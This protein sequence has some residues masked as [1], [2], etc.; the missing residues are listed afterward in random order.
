M[1]KFLMVLIVLFGFIGVVAGAVNVVGPEL[2]S[3]GYRYVIGG[4]VNSFIV[5]TNQQVKSVKEKT[6]GIIKGVCHMKGWENDPNNAG[7]YIINATTTTLAKECGLGWVRFDLSD[8][9][10]DKNGNETTG[11]KNFKEQARAYHK[12]GFKVMVVTPYP[13]EYA[14]WDI[15]NGNFG[16]I[17]T[18]EGQAFLAK[19]AKYI[20]EDLAE[21]VDAIQITNEMPV[22]RFRNPYTLEEAAN[23]IRIQLKAMSEV[24]AEKNLNDNVIIGYNVADFSMYSFYELLSDCNCY[25]DYLGVDLYLGC[26]ESTFKDLFIYDFVLRGFFGASGLPIILNEFGYIGAGTPM[27]DDDKNAYLQ[28]TYGYANEAAATADIVNLLKHE[29]FN[30]EILVHLMEELKNIDGLTVAQS[31]A[32]IDTLTDTEKAKVASML[33]DPDDTNTYCQHF[34]KCLNEGFQLTNYEHTLEGQKNFYSDLINDHLSKMPFLLGCFVYC[35]AD[36]DECY[37]CGSAECPV[38]T[39]WGLVSMDGDYQYNTS[40]PKPCYNAIKEAFANWK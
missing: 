27:D 30:E 12:A 18:P 24:E 10:L 22:N 36:S 15:G 7:E 25:C 9:A 17:R 8:P 16:D 3:G 4:F 2:D 11:Y 33:F 23:Y 40:T 29:S 13:Q 39:G 14:E 34:Y 1:K 37:I 20:R 31:K 21:V 32:Y 35:W 28:Q 19:D 5:P 38:E 26:F 6:G